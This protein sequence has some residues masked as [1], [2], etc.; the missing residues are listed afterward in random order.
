MTRNAEPTPPPEEWTSHEH[1]A[2]P[3]ELQ[4]K[5]LLQAAGNSEIAKHAIDVASGVN[6]NQVTKADQLAESIGF[7]SYRA[8][9]ESSTPGP[10]IEERQWYVTPISASEFVLWN[11][12]ECQVVGAFSTAKEALDATF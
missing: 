3:V 11:D 2:P 8:L 12:R 5:K 9:I 6:S 4:A 10:K 7:R 1:I